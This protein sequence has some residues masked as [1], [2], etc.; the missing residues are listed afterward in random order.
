MSVEGEIRRFRKDLKKARTK[1]PEEV[2]K[3]LP[4]SKVP[5]APNAAEEP[6]ATIR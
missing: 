2:E 3:H 1:T 4:A 6:S 5:A